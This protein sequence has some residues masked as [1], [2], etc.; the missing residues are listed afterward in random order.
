MKFS[1]E[2]I[3]LMKEL[4]KLSSAINKEVAFDFCLNSKNEIV[5]CSDGFNTA[6]VFIGNKDFVYSPPVFR[7]RIGGF[8]THPK[9]TSRLTACDMSFIA[10]NKSK[11]ECVGTER[12]ILCYVCEHEDLNGAKRVECRLKN[13]II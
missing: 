10:H 9:G 1:K 12:G 11:V 8:H 2:T 6:I 13:V 7:E 3:K 5:P 4:T